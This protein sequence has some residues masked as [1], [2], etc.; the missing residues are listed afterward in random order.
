MTRTFSFSCRPD[1]DGGVSIQGVEVF[2]N[3][4]GK[5]TGQASSDISANLSDDDKTKLL[6]LLTSLQAVLE[7]Q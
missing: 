6:A 2:K 1:G 4:Q 5:Q 7:A 3:S